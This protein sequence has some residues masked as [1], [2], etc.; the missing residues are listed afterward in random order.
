MS[1]ADSINK[2]IRKAY[3]KV[4]KILGYDFE[5]FR[6]VDLN[7]QITNSAYIDTKPAAFSVDTKFSRSIAADK[8]PVYT[9]YV[10]GL[11]DSLFDL[12]QGDI[13]Y[14]EETGETYITTHV[15]TH[16]AIQ[17]FLC[18]DK[19]S[20]YATAYSNPGTGFAG[21]DTEV[22]TNVPCYID[23]RGPSGGDLGYIPAASYGSDT[24]DRATVY[25]WDPQGELSRS[26]ILVDSKGRRWTVLS[27]VDSTLIGT[28]L[29]VE[30]QK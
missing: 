20:V 5:I 6:P 29:Q 10:D 4:G 23:V 12:Q 22:A 2:K 13:L 7:T 27:A 30:E 1:K 18:N 21:S 17:A 15:E 28:V 3:G 26:N 14:R 9:A 25:C 24:Y 8:L 16:K 19:V 11:L